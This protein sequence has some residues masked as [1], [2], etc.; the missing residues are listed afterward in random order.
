MKRIWLILSV[1]FTVFDTVL[2]AENTVFRTQPMVS[3]IKTLQV[4]VDGD[5]MKLPVIDMEQMSELEISFDYLADEQPWLTYSIVHCNADW[6]MD[7]L[8]EM[9][10]VEGFFPKRIEDVRP[11][12]NTFISYYHYSVR[13][14]DEDVKLTASGNYAVLIHPDDDD[15]EI[16]AVAT[17]SV[18]EKLAFV[19]GAVSVNTDIDYKQSHQQMS[20]QVSWSNNNLPYLDAASELEVVIRQ[21]R[22]DETR[23]SA[24]VPSRM[25]SGHAVY[26]NNRNLIF[27]AGNNYRRFEFTDERYATIGVDNIRY[28]A[29]YYCVS[30]R[31]DK[32]RNA[33]N[34]LFDKDQNGR[35]L[36]RALRVTDKN[37]EAEYFKA[38]FTLKAPAMFD[39]KDIYISGDFTSGQYL[40]EFRM[41]HDDE[42]GLYW[43]DVVLKQGAYNYMYVVDGDPSAIEGNFYEAENEYDLYV[44]YRPNGARYDRL[45]GVSILASDNK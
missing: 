29:P 36:I 41:Q 25:E 15:E 43:K 13:I 38:R 6:Q 45:L 30:L 4:I 28:E 11:S 17:F 34:F 21:N 42:T 33:S 16:V 8:S 27:D 35:Y 19:K 39:R 1:L 2:Y 37:I 23:R 7:D 44:Y 32:P 26:E 31:Q 18:S 14:P 9:D 10:Y 40:D 12:F 5:F 3:E 22:R 20:F 24:G